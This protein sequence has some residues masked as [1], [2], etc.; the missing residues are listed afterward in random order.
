MVKIV[1]IVSGN[2]RGRLVIDQ[3]RAGGAMQSASYIAPSG[4]FHSGAER[5]LVVEEVA[6]ALGSVEQI[7]E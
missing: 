1:A 3:K 5:W 7:L 2:I 4:T 6:F